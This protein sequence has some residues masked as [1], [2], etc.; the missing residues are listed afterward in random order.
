MPTLLA[1]FTRL[2][3]RRPHGPL[4]FVL[5]LVTM[6]IMPPSVAAQ[7]RV[8]SDSATRATRYFRDAA[9]G[10]AIGLVWAGVDQL[11]NDPVEWGKG[12]RGYGKRAASSVG[13]FLIQES[14]T[15]LLANSMDRPLDYQP[16]RCRHMSR[17]IGWALQAA[18]T[19]PMPNDTHPIAIPRI[20][21]SYAGSF[22]Q[23][24]WRPSTTNRAQT[25]LVNGT[26]SLAIGGAINIFHE[27]RH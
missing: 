25:A 20:L 18:V 14:V 8:G 10:S 3:S 16:C 6:S 21:G 23:A 17:R 27:L 13:Q 7:R 5:A 1:R 22:A 19:D 24:G 12:W 4:L 15:H 11:R 26:I 9:Q 2:A